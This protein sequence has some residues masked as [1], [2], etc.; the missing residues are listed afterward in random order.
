MHVQ[1]IV[2]YVGRRLASALLGLCPGADY[3]YQLVLK[4]FCLHLYLGSYTTSTGYY[5]SYINFIS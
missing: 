4:A 3:P 5:C 2:G 1:R